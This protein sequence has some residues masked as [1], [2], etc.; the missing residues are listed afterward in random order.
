MNLGQRNM[1]IENRDLFEIIA[2]LNFK[3]IKIHLCALLANNWTCCLR[4]FFKRACLNSKGRRN[5]ELLER[6]TQKI[7]EQLD[8]RNLIKMQTDIRILTNLLLTKPQ[9]WLFKN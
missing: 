2:R 8:I 9:R 6:G 4:I 1:R 5:F 3:K 7:D